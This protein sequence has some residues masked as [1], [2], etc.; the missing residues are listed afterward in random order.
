[1]AA[2]D[3]FADMFARVRARDP[4]ATAAFVRHYEAQLR[5]KVR[6]WL[7]LHYPYLRNLLDSV[8]VCQSVLN[9]FR[10]RVALGQCDL[11][12][13][14]D[15]WNLLVEMSRCRLRQHGHDQSADRRNARRRAAVGSGVLA[16]VP[17]GPSPSQ[18]VSARDLLEAVRKRLTNEEWVV[19]ERRLAGCSWAEA[20]TALGGTADGCRMKLTRALD[21]VACDLG[22]EEEL[23]DG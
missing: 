20:A 1:M 2:D 15:V 6:T 22:L 10:L 12:T 9:G 23:A 4:E 13:P 11:E 19:A 18:V 5:R 7:Q 3:A 16:A 8:D 17:Q 14:Q 21:R